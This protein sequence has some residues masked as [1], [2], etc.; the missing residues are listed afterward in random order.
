VRF[1]SPLR[2]RG[3]TVRASELLVPTILRSLVAFPNNFRRP[4]L[5]IILVDEDGDGSRQALAASLDGSIVPAVMGVA[6]P[7]FEAWLIADH[8]N[9]AQVLR[10]TIDP[11]PATMAPRAAK[12]FLSKAFSCRSGS[13]DPAELRK[14]LA[15]SCDFKALMRVRSFEMLMKE[16]G[17]VL[18]AR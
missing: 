18:T 3:K 7:E 10:T 11:P 8:A 17:R 13:S 9:L 6:V 12:A 15:R 1:V 16:I 2:P 4:D 5:A 14:E